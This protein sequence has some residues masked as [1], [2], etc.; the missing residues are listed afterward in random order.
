MHVHGC[1]AVLT[2]L[3]CVM[4]K[5]LPSLMWEKIMSTTLMMQ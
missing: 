4:R 1:K 5:E 3:G 2:G